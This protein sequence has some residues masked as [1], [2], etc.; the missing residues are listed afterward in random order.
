V[1]IAGIGTAGT[2][3]WSLVFFGARVAHAVIYTFGVPLLRTI[4][5]VIGFAAQVMLAVH[6][7]GAA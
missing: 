1:H 2:A 7:L 3:A 5:F 4:A 6:I